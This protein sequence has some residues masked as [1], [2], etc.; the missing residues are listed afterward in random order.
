MTDAERKQAV[1]NNPAIVFDGAY[2]NQASRQILRYRIN[3]SSPFFEDDFIDFKSLV[4]KLKNRTGPVSQFLRDQFDTSAQSLLNAY[5]E[6]QEPSETLKNAVVKELNWVLKGDSIYGATRFDGINLSPKT[7]QLLEQNPQGEDLI[8]LNRLL[9]EDAYPEEIEKIQINDEGGILLT[10][11]GSKSFSE[12]FQGAAPEF[13]PGIPPW[14]LSGQIVLVNDGTGKSTSDACEGNFVNADEIRGRI[15]LI[16][17]GDCFFVDKVKRAQDAGAVA[18]VITNNVEDGVLNMGLGE[19][20]IDIAIPSVF[21]SKADGDLIKAALVDEK[22]Y[23]SVSNQ[24]E[25]SGTQ[26]NLIN[27]DPL[28]ISHWTPDAFPNLLM[29]PEIS[30]PTRTD[31]D[32]T[33]TALRDIGWKISNIPFT[34]LSFE[35][36][37]NEQ[38]SGAGN[39]LDDDP[40]ADGSVN[41]MEYAFG[42]DPEDAAS[43]PSSV[44]FLP[45][46]DGGNL[47]TLKYKRSPAPADIIFSVNKTNSLKAPFT[48]TIGG[49]ECRQFNRFV[50]EDGLENMEFQIESAA[51]QQFFNVEVRIYSQ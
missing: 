6:S 50:D 3:P 8:F 26:N 51:T 41:L 13:G 35:L 5:N 28:S 4:L 14:G 46:G 22:L 2:T 42:T 39:G 44:K 43:I 31:L 21:I 32:L 16:D 15:A 27:V 20:Y 45:S 48:E 34:Y 47:F 12:S 37:A 17:R 25:F 36:W 7:K 19:V 38:I 10:I 11:N 29:E 9:L 1:A 30:G 23:V 24:R 18:A 33:L 40:D 49:S